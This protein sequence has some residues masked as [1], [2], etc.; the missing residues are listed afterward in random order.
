MLQAKVLVFLSTCKQVKLR[1]R[2][3]PP[4]APGRAAVAAIHGKMKQMRRMAVFYD[5]CEARHP[6]A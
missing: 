6:P 2:G 5:F 4:P 3:L 1:V